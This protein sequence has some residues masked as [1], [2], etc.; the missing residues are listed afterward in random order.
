MTDDIVDAEFSSVLKMD[1]QVTTKSL[2]VPTLGIGRKE[3][4]S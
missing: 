2:K 4:K 3:V 1:L